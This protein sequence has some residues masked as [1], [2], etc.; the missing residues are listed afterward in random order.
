[1]DRASDE[2]VMARRGMGTGEETETVQVVGEIRGR[3]LSFQ[4][5]IAITT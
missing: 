1:M 3:E 4:G 5:S 2:A